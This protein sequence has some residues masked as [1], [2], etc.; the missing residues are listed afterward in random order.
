MGP[1]SVGYTRRRVGDEEEEDGGESSSTEGTVEGGVLNFWGKGNRG[2]GYG[3]Q[4]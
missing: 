3:F 4:E 2:D 1:Y